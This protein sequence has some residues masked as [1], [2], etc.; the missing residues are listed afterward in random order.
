M[1]LKSLVTYLFVI[2]VSSF[3]PTFA[4]EIKLEVADGMATAICEHADCPTHIW[5]VVQNGKL[6]NVRQYGHECLFAARPGSYVIVCLCQMADKSILQCSGSFTIGN[7]PQPDNPQPNP[8]PDPDPPNP[9]PP[10]PDPPQPDPTPVPPKPT[11]YGLDKFAFNQSAGLDRIEVINMAKMLRTVSSAAAAGGYKNVTA[12][13]LDTKKRMDTLG[14]GEW[15]TFRNKMIDELNR[16]GFR[17]LD[18]N[19]F[20]IAWNEIALGLERRVN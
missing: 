19:E 4:D 9:N 17:S 18:I 2:L 7:N 13:L 14:G 15:H 5:T 6:I 11:K 8:N 3:Q 20:V 1:K 12:M 16:M 10:E